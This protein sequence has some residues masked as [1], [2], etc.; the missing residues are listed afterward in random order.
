MLNAKD[1]ARMDQARAYLAEHLPPL[2]WSIFAGC[3][4]QGFSR[5]ES[6]MLVMNYVRVTTPQPPPMKSED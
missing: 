4:K 1:S 2:W 3:V 6:L 5:E